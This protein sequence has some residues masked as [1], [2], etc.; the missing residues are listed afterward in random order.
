MSCCDGR[1]WQTIF[2]IIK[3]RKMEAKNFISGQTGLQ[4]INVDSIKSRHRP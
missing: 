3:E 2:K 4:E 1:K